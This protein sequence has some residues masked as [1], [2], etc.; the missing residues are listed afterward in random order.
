[1]TVDSLRS[2]ID[3]GESFEYLAFYGHRAHRRNEL[4]R[5]CMSQWFASP[6]AIDGMTYQTAEHYMMAE[7]ARLFGDEAFAR[8]IIESASPADAKRLGRQVRGFEADVWSRHRF[9]IVVAGN[10]AKFS[11]TDPLKAFLLETGDK[12]LVEASPTDRI[13][14]VGLA[15]DA[16][17]VTDP[18]AW[19]GLNLLGFALMAARQALR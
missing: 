14:G 8:R 1:M 12:V 7:K 16:P 15:L 5:S 3:G 17:E 10:I 4:T 9:D 6:F 13:W 19:Q 2:R 11:S 18:H